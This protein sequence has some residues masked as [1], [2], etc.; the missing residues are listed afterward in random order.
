MRISE[1][2]RAAECTVRTIRH[3]HHKGVLDEPPRDSNGYRNYGIADLAELLRIRALVQA[4]VPLSLV[5]SDTALE[6]ARELLH[7]RITQ[8]LQQQIFLERLS[9]HTVGV[10][11]DVRESLRTLITD[12]HLYDQEITAL[13]VMALTGITTPATWQVLR[14]NLAHPKI[15]QSTTRFL[16]AWTTLMQEPSVDIDQM[17]EEFRVAY[18]QGWMRGVAETLVEGSVD[19]SLPDMHLEPRVEQ[20]L[21]QFLGQ[22]Q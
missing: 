13:E 11:S 6:Q 8:L 5:T 10:P 16:Q 19:V 14:E 2:A 4:G 12:E 20:V 3:Y 18:E 7:I 15:Q 17:V 21:S 9:A 22:W 1:L